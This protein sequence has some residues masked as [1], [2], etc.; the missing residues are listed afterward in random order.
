MYTSLRDSFQ[1]SR[2]GRKR[3]VR[4]SRSITR[5]VF[6]LEEDDSPQIDPCAAGESPQF[7]L[8]LASVAGFVVPGVEAKLED[9]GLDI[10]PFV[11]LLLGDVFHLLSGPHRFQLFGREVPPLVL[12]PVC[13]IGDAERAAPGP[14]GLIDLSGS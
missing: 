9:G 7:M 4:G 2:K 6:A 10:V 12:G 14:L 8:A 5:S 3:A 11:L 1:E 13:R